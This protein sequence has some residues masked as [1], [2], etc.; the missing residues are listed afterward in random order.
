MSVCLVAGGEPHL[1]ERARLA[2][3][4]Q[5]L[6]D[7]ERVVAMPSARAGTEAAGVAARLR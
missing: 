2:Y 1:L 6:G 4:R 3:E 5:D 7:V